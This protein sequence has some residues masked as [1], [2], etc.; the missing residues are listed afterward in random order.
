MDHDT[1]DIDMMNDVIN[2]RNTKADLMGGFFYILKARAIN[3]A[4]VTIKDLA[5]P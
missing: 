5:A 2:V 3:I 1:L 4:L